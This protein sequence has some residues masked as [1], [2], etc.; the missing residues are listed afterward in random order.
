MCDGSGDFRPLRSY[1]SL[2]TG[3]KFQKENEGFSFYLGLEFPHERE[4]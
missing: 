4:I 3:A 1:E 2:K